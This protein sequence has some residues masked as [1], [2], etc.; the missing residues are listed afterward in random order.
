VTVESA[1]HTFRVYESDELLAEDARTTTNPIA[2]FKVRKPEAPRGAHD[3][4]PTSCANKLQRP[5]VAWKA[6]TPHLL[7]SDALPARVGSG[8]RQNHSSLYGLALAGSGSHLTQIIGGLPV[9][10]QPRGARRMRRRVIASAFAAGSLD[11]WKRIAAFLS[12]IPRCTNGSRPRHNTF[13]WNSRRCRYCTPFVHDYAR[14]VV[15]RSHRP[16]NPCLA[17]Q[18][19]S[20][21]SSP[22][23]CRQSRRQE[24]ELW[25]SQAVCSFTVRRRRQLRDSSSD[26]A[27][28]IFS[29]VPFGNN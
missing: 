8:N 25:L 21:L 18:F 29:L 12:A 14:V 16:A 6:R 22:F 11:R 24:Q 15:S 19:C 5:V 23:A 13:A 7:G 20:S 17:D 10:T 1:D 3:A 27:M 9:R 2:R 28:I 26:I 4:P